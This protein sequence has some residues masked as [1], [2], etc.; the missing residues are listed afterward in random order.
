MSKKWRIQYPVEIFYN[1]IKSIGIEES[2]G[3]SLSKPIIEWPTNK[4][5][6]LVFTLLSDE[7][8]K[9]YVDHFTYSNLAEMIGDIVSRVVSCGNTNY[10]GKMA[11]DILNVDNDSRTK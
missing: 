7:K 1:Q 11:C 10:D 4:K 3:N 5:T 9:I 2:K 6:F 8:R